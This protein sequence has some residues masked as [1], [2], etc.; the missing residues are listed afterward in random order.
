M[1]QQSK[2]GM[3][4]SVLYAL[5]L[6]S[7]LQKFEGEA[8]AHEGAKDFGIWLYIIVQLQTQELVEILDALA[9]SA[10]KSLWAT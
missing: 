6:F 8:T 5:D 2:Q 1:W 3:S 9:Y 10:H 7:Q 4:A